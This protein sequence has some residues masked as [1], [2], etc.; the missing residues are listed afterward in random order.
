MFTD[1]S[2]PTERAQKTWQLSANKEQ[3]NLIGTIKH[4]LSQITI[5]RFI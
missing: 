1:T 3:P 5:I 2:N 4:A